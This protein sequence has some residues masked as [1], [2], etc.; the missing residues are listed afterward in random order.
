M[1]L[2]LKR[3]QEDDKQTIGHLFVREPN[4]G[5][6]AIFAT[7]ELPFKENKRNISCIPTGKYQVVKRWS[8]KYGNHFHIL[9]VMGR[10]MILMHAGNYFGQTQGCVLLGWFHNDIN[11]DGRLDTVNSVKCMQA[12]NAMI[13]DKT[14]YLEVSNVYDLEVL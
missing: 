11:K 1:Y 13:T 9:D 2:E 5:V 3:I 12:L 10:S 4:G 14:T 8:I 6:I 7:L